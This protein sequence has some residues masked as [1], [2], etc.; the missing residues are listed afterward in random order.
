M[1]LIRN[2]NFVRRADKEEGRERE[3]ERW[4]EGAVAWNEGKK[5]T[6]YFGE[7]RSRGEITRCH[8]R[9]VPRPNSLSASPP[10]HSR[11]SLPSRH[12]RFEGRA[13]GRRK[14][15]WPTIRRLI[16]AII[17]ARRFAFRL[18]PP[19]LT[20]L[21]LTPILGRFAGMLASS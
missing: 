2:R 13:R 1:S 21:Y 9:F 4:R 6:C 19:P 15:G 10:K 5:G 11:L 20:R 18:P 14:R 17:V 12:P 16:R 3:R 7:A 8:T